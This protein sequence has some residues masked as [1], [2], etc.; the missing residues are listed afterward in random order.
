MFGVLF[1]NFVVSPVP[2]VY[3]L[4]TPQGL[5]ASVDCE[6]SLTGSNRVG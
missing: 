1:V 2:F 6:T 4:V 5:T 3:V